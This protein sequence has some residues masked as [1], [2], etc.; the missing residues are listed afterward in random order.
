MDAKYNCWRH[1]LRIAICSMAVISA[2]YLL[3]FVVERVFMYVLH[4]ARISSGSSLPNTLLHDRQWSRRWD[5]HLNASKSQHF[6]LGIP[7]TTQ[8]WGRV[9]VLGVTVNSVFTTSYGVLIAANKA[10]GMIN[11]IKTVKGDLRTPVQ[12]STT[13]TEPTLHYII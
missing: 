1:W 10:N 12:L 13:L 7:E 9:K 4:C 8:T 3:R 5:L 6:K 2:H 11:F